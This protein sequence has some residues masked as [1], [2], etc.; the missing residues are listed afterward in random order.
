MIRMSYF[1]YIEERL[2][3]L[4][5]R[6]IRRGHFN[7]YDI[8]LQCENFYLH[9]MNLIYGWNLK[10]VNVINRNE[11]AVDL[12]YEAEKL[13]VQVSS[14]CTREKIQNSLNKLNQKYDG[15]RFKFVSIAKPA[16]NLRNPQYS[17]PRG[18]SIFFD[19]QND[20]YDIDGI[21]ANVLTMKADDQKEVYEFVKSELHF[22]TAQLKLETGLAHVI[23]ALSD[24]DLEKSKVFFDKESY[25]IDSKI[26]RNNLSVF[27]DVIEEYDVYYTTVQRIY[28]DYDRMA[29][30]KSYAVLQT[31]NREYLN[32]KSQHCGDDLYKAI[33]HNIKERLAMSANLN[34][35]N[36]DEVELYVDIILVDAFIRCKIFEK[37]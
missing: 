27:K 15:F 12:I 1:D 11:P 24:I 14:T 32:L 16:E 36:D 31:I 2:N 4:S 22:D 20:I 23:N 8:N 21:L 26:I 30:N 13:V 29:N 7:M 33:A 18:F 10:N 28:D 5:F 6:I 25:D 3:F 9:L 34:E 17:L 37:P 35:F 19:S